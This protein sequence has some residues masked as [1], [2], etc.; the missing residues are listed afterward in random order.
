MLDDLLRNIQGLLQ[1]LWAVCA[2]LFA[3]GATFSFLT[4]P[5]V[6]LAGRLHEPWKV[7]L[8]GG[9]ASAAGSAAQF[10]VLR[11]VLAAGHPW[12]KR[13]TP[14]RDKLEAALRQYPSA[15]FMAI[16]LAR[17]LPLP[18]APIKLVAA[19]VEYPVPRYGVAVFLGALPYYFAL[20]LAGQKLRIPGW[21]IVAGLGVFAVAALVDALRKRGRRTA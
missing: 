19:I 17:A 12:M 15:S 14:S 20:A 5:I 13:W 3:D 2:L 8:F 18:D 4:T 16:L 10:A 11:W 6:Y 7:A 9:L 1:H 21:V